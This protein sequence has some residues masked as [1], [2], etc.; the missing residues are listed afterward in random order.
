MKIREGRSNPQRKLLDHSIEKYG[1]HLVH[2]TRQLFN[3]MVLFSPFIIFFAIFEQQSSRWLFQA[4][5]MNGDI[6]FYIIQ[7]DQMQ[8]TNGILVLLFVPIF[9]TVIY[10]LMNKIG[11]RQ[12]LRRMSLGGFFICISCL[13]SALVQFKIETSPENSVNML[14]LVPQYIAI[15]IGE[16]MFSVTSSSFAYEQA[17]NDMRS[18]VQALLLLNIAFSNLIVLFTVEFTV[19]ERQSYEFLLFT[20]IMF[21]DML[22]FMGLAYK[23]NCKTPNE[24]ESDDRVP[25]LVNNTSEE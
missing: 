2:K 13:L 4:S 17:P 21:V 25:I 18:V 3:I 8:I 23:F 10:P 22:V 7:P 9:D 11:F 5:K 12:P 6:G 24:V 15:T 20:S 16:I 19:F 1:E 14:W